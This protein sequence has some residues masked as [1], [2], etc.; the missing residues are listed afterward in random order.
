MFRREWLRNVASFV[1]AIPFCFVSRIPVVPK[2]EDREPTKFITCVPFNSFEYTLYC[3]NNKPVRFGRSCRT[4]H[5]WPDNPLRLVMGTLEI[6][7]Q[8]FVKL[9]NTLEEITGSK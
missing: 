9:G 1:S 2:R 3:I 6:N 8:T 5:G 7:G 4:D